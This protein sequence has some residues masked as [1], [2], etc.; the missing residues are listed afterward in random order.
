VDVNL[1]AS[2]TSPD[3]NTGLDVTPPLRPSQAPLPP[4]SKLLMFGIA[5]L[6]GAST[7]GAALAPYLAV[8]YPLI[9]IA[10]N[11][12]PRH[13]ILVAPHTPLIPLV[14]VVA[15]RGLFSCAIAYEVG[16]H[17]GPRGIELFERRSPRIAGLLRAFERVFSRAAPAFLVASPGPLTSTLA[18]VSGNSRW[19][20]WALSWIGFV[21]WSLINYQVG[22][23]LKPW[24][25]P[26]LAFI[27]R[28]LFETTLACIVLVFGYQWIARK[29]RLKQAP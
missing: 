29:R 13:V 19:A 22:D 11:P 25:A 23:W 7:L 20:T 9:L 26:I 4:L 1:D 14:L 28:Y 6:F 17:Y 10:L 15:F 16:I 24:T 3:L 21:I 12:W 5:V 18:A 8:K 27:Q 2:R